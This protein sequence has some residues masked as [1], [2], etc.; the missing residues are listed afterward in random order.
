M[1]KKRVLI[2]S[3][4]VVGNIMAGPG[5][6]YHN[7]ANELGKHFSVTLGVYSPNPKSSLK[8]NYVLKHVDVQKFHKAF[9]E[10]D[11]ILA[12][13]LN[14]DMISYARASGKLII[15]DLYA[16]V[17][18]EVLASMLL[19]DN[20]IT[21]IDDNEFRMSVD[22]Y[23]R[24]FEVGD[25]FT[26]S[27]IRQ[28][29]WWIGFA[30]GGNSI[31]PSK[32]RGQDIYENFVLAPMGINDDT[33]EHTKN[34]LKGVVPGIKKEDFVIVWTGGI[35]DWF[36]GTTP[37]KAMQKLT[38]HKDIKLVFLGTKH[39]NKDIPPGMS[40]TNRTYELAKKLD[41]IDKNVYFL[42]G[43]LGYE[44]RINYLLEA[45][46]AIYAHKDSIEAQFSHRTRVLDHIYATLPT[47]ATKGDYFADVIAK[48]SLGVAVDIGDDNAMSK[49]ILEIKA[50]IEVYKKNIKKV[51]D[52]YKWSNTT[53][54][55]VKYI[56]TVDP[57]KSK[58]QTAEYHYVKPKTS[59]LLLKKY[60]PVPIKR[61]IRRVI[62][63]R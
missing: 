1:N 45:D 62:K 30:F 58:K 16:P 5:I 25:L 2:L 49:A 39:P 52:T 9:D 36:D 26:C 12:M 34:V 35:W 47:V 41:L 60:V 3:H 4:D 44:D 55:L 17:Q 13:W 31:V 20:K 28:L 22:S 51:R 32:Y 6:R 14:E 63:K 18:V 27:N 56:D 15:F 33:P 59:T 24:F 57:S 53:L 29:D 43:W 23:R 19:K 42:E 10:H 61:Q 21:P 7:I 11:F 37:I 54:P 46:A 40:E 38:T 50:N 8:S 48:D